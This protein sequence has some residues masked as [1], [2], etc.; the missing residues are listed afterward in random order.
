MALIKGETVVLIEPTEEG[1]DEFNAPI[2]TEIEVEVANVVVGS[3]ESS[4]VLEVSNL[5]GK[6]LAY[7]LCIPKGDTHKWYD[8]KVRIR[9]EM[10]ATVGYPKEYNESFV[11]LDWNKQVKVCRYE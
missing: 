3:P 4:D 2:A 5:Y 9:G 1:M 10:Y 6:K 7:T 11:P 8:A